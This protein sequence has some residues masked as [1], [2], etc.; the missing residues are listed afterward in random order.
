MKIDFRAFRLP[1]FFTRSLYNRVKNRPP[2]VKTALGSR[3]KNRPKQGKIHLRKDRHGK[4]GLSRNGLLESSDTDMY[5]A[6]STRKQ[7]GNWMLHPQ[8]IIYPFMFLMIP[9]PYSLTKGFSCLSA[10]DVKYW[11]V[12]ELAEFISVT[13]LWKWDNFRHFELWYNIV[14]TRTF[15]KRRRKSWRFIAQDS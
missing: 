14:E 13:Y 11:K 15:G 2:Y 3:R 9:L 1:I 10:W 8:K 6:K 4:D 12:Y 7:N 5:L